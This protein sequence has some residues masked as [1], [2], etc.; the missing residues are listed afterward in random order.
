MSMQT[1]SERYGYKKV[2]GTFQKENIDE[3]LKTALWNIIYFYLIDNNTNLFTHVDYKNQANKILWTNFFHRKINDF[4]ISD[5]GQFFERW[6]FV[7]AKW[8]EIYDILQEFVLI[9]EF[10]KINYQNFIIAIN[11]KLE[12]HMSVYKFVNTEIFEITSED[13]I[14]EIETAVNSPL[15]EVNIQLKNALHHL[16]DREKPDYRNSINESISAVECICRKIT[17]QGDLAKSIAHLEEKGIKLNARLKTGMSNL[18]QY[19]NDKNGIRH[20]LM[21]MSEEVNME[22]ARFMLITCSAFVNYLLEKANKLGI[23]L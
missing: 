21:D 14:K 18:Y 12:M 16:S 6:F 13:E 23:K 22:E 1:F 2:R 8:Y 17:G 3:N 7:N 15:K 20:S 10:Q 11:R 9:L 5:F 4:R 19:T